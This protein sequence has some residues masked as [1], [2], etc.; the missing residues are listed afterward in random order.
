MNDPGWFL[1]IQG[2]EPSFEPDGPGVR[3]VDTLGVGITGPVGRTTLPMAS[4]SA[5]C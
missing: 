5:C 4:D 3:I 1:V 2:E